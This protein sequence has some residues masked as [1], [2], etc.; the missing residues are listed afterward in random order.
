MRITYILITLSIQLTICELK[1][2]SEKPVDEF[3]SKID[4]YLDSISANASAL[5]IT[6]SAS[7]RKVRIKGKFDNSTKIFKQKIKYYKG[8][9]KKEK[10]KVAKEIDGKPYVLLKIVR[11]NDE[12]FYINKKTYSTEYPKKVIVTE[13]LIDKKIYC[14]IERNHELGKYNRVDYWENK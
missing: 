5:Q 7:N 1:G 10:I 13:K 2:Q 14:S 8:Y 12:Y 4:Y 11:I 3:V 9:L 6:A